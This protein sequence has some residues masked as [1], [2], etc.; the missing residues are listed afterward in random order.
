[1]VKRATLFVLAM[2]LVFGI[3]LNNEASAQVATPNQTVIT[4][5][6][7]PT[8]TTSLAVPVTV[9]TAVVK[10][11]TASSSVSGALVVV[12]SMSEG[13]GIVSTTGDLP[14]SFTITG[15]LTGV[16]AGT[17]AV[18]LGAVAD[19]LG[20]TAIAGATAASSVSSVTVASSS[21]STSSTSSTSSTG[22]GALDKSTFTI[23]ITGEAIK[24]TSAVNVTSAFADTSI[25]TIDTTGITVTGT[26]ISQ[27]LTD[28]NA[29]TGVIS[30]V[31]SGTSTDGTITISGKLKPGSMA[32]T[33]TFG[34][35]KVEAQGGTDVT[36]NVATVVDPTSIT[37]G[38]STSG[39]SATFTLLTP[40][41]V[42][43]PGKAAV[44][45]TASGVTTGT[46]A[47]LN[48]ANVSFLD[49]NKVGI[50]IVDVPSSGSLS[51]SLVSTVSGMSTTTSLGSISVTAGTGKAPKVK[52]AKVRN[53]AS[54][55]KLTVL[56]MAFAPSATTVTIIPTDKTATTTTSS[57]STVK[58]NYA[59]ADCIP[60]G[61]FVNVTTAAGTSAKKIT[62][63]G[64]CTNKLV[65]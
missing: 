64:A 22:G 26:G 52:S 41:T 31:W 46:T 43:G 39:G 63:M 56:G 27:L 58:A 30:A 55:T 3:T 60:N 6:G 42:T 40:T 48:G 15:A 8:G 44:S 34:V 37:N 18:T 1:M 23:M 61:S 45:F 25:A 47:K 33:T 7:V 32:G 19:M 13:I 49:S 62:V 21:T 35:S 5:S 14:A 59:S 50:A 20:G 12:G 38:S 16:T 17:S 65:P 11:G 54:A 53:N 4:V 9:D 36:A 10:L 51:L 24:G 57:K 28:A 2:L 29:S